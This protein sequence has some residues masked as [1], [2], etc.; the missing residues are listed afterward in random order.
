MSEMTRL[1]KE[2]VIHVGERGIFHFN[3][4]GGRRL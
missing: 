2:P 1:E 4:G 3:D